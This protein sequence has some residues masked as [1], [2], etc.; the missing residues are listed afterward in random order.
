MLTDDSDLEE[1]RTRAARNQTVFREV[2]ERIVELSQRWITPPQFI[3]ECEN[4]RC[5]ETVVATMDVY[6]AVRG[7]PA[8]FLVARG[9]EVPDVEEI[10]DSADGFVVVRTLGQGLV[11]AVEFDPRKADGAGL[12]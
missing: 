5:A 1:R 7:D 11:V 12:H 3:C 10:V 9:H 8:C 6:E 2:N 4:P